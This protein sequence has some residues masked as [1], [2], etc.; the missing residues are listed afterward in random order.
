[1]GKDYLIVS[2]P[3]YNEYVSKLKNPNQLNQYNTEQI[4]ELRYNQRFTFWA[5]WI[6]EIV[7]VT[8]LLR[9]HFQHFCYIMCSKREL[10]VIS[11]RKDRTLWF[12]LGLWFTESQ[13]L[14]VKWC[15]EGSHAHPK[16]TQTH[17]CHMQMHSEMHSVM[18]QIGG[19]LPLHWCF[20][21]C[22]SKHVFTELILSEHG[23]HRP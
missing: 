4:I 14:Q 6:C 2:D 18:R 8:W 3:L 9:F 11:Q 16:G 19:E 10:M 13:A 5:S 20:S 7:V 1:M 23:D 22:E 12:N 21:A 15:F 17:P